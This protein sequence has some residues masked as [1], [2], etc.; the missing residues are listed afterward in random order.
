MLSQSAF[1]AFLKTLD[2]VCEGSLPEGSLKTLLLNGGECVSMNDTEHVYMLDDKLLTVNFEYQD[3]VFN[4]KQLIWFGSS[5][6]IVVVYDSLTDT[7]VDTAVFT[8]ANGYSLKR[9]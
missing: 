3:V 8:L 2:L 1:N 9:A 4:G 5:D 7:V 6:F